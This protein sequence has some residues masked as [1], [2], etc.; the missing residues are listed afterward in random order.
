MTAEQI[1]AVRI[2]LTH[3]APSITRCD[4]QRAGYIVGSCSEDD[5]EVWHGMDEPAKA[6]GKHATYDLQ[7]VFIGHRNRVNV[8]ARVT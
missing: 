2:Q 3:H 7:A 1:D 6:C 8:A 4:A 5:V